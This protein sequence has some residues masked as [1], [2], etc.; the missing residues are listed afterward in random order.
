LLDTANAATLRVWVYD[1]ARIAAAS[2]DGRTNGNLLALAAL[3]GENGVEQR[4]TGI[5]AGHAQQLAAA[6]SEAAAV[7]AWREN[8]FAALDETT[9]IDLDREAADLLRFQQAYSACTRIIQV[10]RETFDDLLNAV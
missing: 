4:W 1:P 9:G 6:K 5:V 3:R 7:G 8:A 2:P 10:G